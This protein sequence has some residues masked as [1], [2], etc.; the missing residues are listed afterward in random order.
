TAKETWSTAVTP[1]N[2]LETP[3][4]A[5]KDIGGEMLTAPRRFL[6]APARGRFLQRLKEGDERRA[7]GGR[8][9]LEAVARAG[10][11]APVQLDRLL[12]RGRPAVMQKMLGAAQVEERLGA[13]IRGGGEAET[14]VGQLG[15]H[16]VQQEIGVGGERLVPQR[17]HGAIPGAQRRDVTGGAAYLGEEVAAAPPVLAELQRRRRR[18]KPHEIVGEVERLLGDLGIG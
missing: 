13:K 15:P 2:R 4:R 1:P 12:E 7:V 11:L 3:S 16:V 14:N 18:E 9:G 8:Q 5:R 10:A 17:R 6:Q